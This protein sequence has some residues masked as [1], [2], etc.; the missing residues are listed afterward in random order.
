MCQMRSGDKTSGGTNVTTQQI[1]DVRKPSE[2]ALHNLVIAKLST[3]LIDVI[4]RIYLFLKA[5][6]L[7]SELLGSFGDNELSPECLDGVQAF[8]KRTLHSLH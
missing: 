7:V 3:L 1:W 8:L 2:V 4:L 6:I 5:D